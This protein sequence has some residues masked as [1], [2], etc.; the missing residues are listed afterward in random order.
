MHWRVSQFERLQA[1]YVHFLKNFLTL[2]KFLLTFLLNF[3]SGQS[4]NF[5]GVPSDFISIIPSFF[6]A[7]SWSACYYQQHDRDLLVQVLFF[8]TLHITVRHH[9]SVQLGHF[10]F[11]QAMAPLVIA[12]DPDLTDSEEEK[13]KQNQ[14]QLNLSRKR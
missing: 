1:W 2:F 3:P 6:S 4:F 9:G 8:L 11:P 12:Q 14:N 13:K 7:Q 10:N 5:E